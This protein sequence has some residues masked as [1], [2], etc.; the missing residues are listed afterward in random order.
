MTKKEMRERLAAIRK[1]AEAAQKENDAK[2]L[3]SLLTEAQDISDKLENAEKLNKLQGIAD[4]HSGNPGEAGDNG[5][6]REDKSTKR[7]RLLM[8]GAKVKMGV[9]KIFN[10][11]TSS[12]TVM[13]VHTASDVKDTFNSVSSIVDAVKIVSLPGGESYKR[14]FVK[15]YGEGDY[16]AEGAAAAT[17]E[18]QFGYAEMNKAKITAYCEEPEEIV[19]L[20]PAAYDNTIA[21]SVAKAV[22][23]KLGRQIMVGAGT[24]NTL[25]GIFNTAN[26]IINGDTD[27][28]IS[29][30]TA[31]TLDEIIYSY[32]G[33]ED[34]EGDCGLIISK[35]DLKAF[36]MLRDDTNGK[37][38]Y[39]IKTNGNT[40]TI[41]GV[42][43]IL[44]SACPALSKAATEAGTFCMAYGPY[45][46]YELPIFS[47]LDVQRSTEYKFKEGQIAHKAEIYAGGNVAAWNGFVRVKKVAGE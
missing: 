35:A 41:D 45:E 7:G 38:S 17:A 28:E 27:V 13:P 8:S 16:T 39:D 14:G 44:N 5:E 33:D 24:S 10:T 37:R 40:G 6:G 2:R 12:S 31:T 15:S 47:D 9:K 11:L 22:R 19:K 3:D 29:E 25:T 36:A 34:V 4:A 42:P 46:N 21:N 43:F 18:P 26:N 20:A 30:I 32:G 23:R 1:E